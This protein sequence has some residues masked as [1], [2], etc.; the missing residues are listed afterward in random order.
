VVVEREEQKFSKPNKKFF[1]AQEQS[2][3]SRGVQSFSVKKCFFLKRIPFVVICNKREKETVPAGVWLYTPF[4][5]T[6]KK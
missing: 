3:L 1:L 2:I 4:S 6:A 5:Q